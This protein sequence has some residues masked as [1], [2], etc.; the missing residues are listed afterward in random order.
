MERIG[1]GEDLSTGMYYTVCANLEGSV[2]LSL[3]DEGRE[4][5]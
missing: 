1:F 3:S 5:K 4:L 2:D